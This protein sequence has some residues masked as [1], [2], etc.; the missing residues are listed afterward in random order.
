M[1]DISA[2]FVTQY[3]AEVHMAY[4]Q[5]ASRLRNAVRVKSGVVGKSDK[6]TRI[7]KGSATQKTRHGAV[8]P[9]EVDHSQVEA[10]LADWYAP[11]YVDRLDEYKIKHDERRAL[12]QSGA[13][14][15]GRKVDELIIAAALDGLPADQI[16]GSQTA[17]LNLDRVLDAFA[18]FNSGDVP[19]DGRRFAVVGPYQWNQLL[20]IDQFAKS[21][22]V[23]ADAP[24]WLKGAEARRWLNILWMMHTGLPGAT[25]KGGA[26]QSLI[27]HQSAL[28]LLEGGSGVTSEI[29]YIAEKVAFLCNNMISAG[30]IR[31]DDAGVVR[32]DAKNTA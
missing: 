17:A 22:Y 25:D 4:Q 11:D 31:I 19:D 3:E 29:N 24:V 30:A 9:M 18:A 2:A 10:F 16:I 5:G 26:T 23:G 28:G 15:V 8:V 14:A 21:G 1:A 6:F 27:F 7:G 20:K 32:L 13:F 12:T